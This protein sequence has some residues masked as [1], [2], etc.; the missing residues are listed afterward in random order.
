[1]GDID[2]LI[3]KEDLKRVHQVFNKEGYDLMARSLSH[4]VFTNKAGLM[5]EIHPGLNVVEEKTYTKLLNKAFDYVKLEEDYEYKFNT[6]Y[7]LTY[8]VYHLAKH[9]YSGGI[10]LRSV[11]DIGV[12]INSYQDDLDEDL[13]GELLKEN[14]LEV[15]FNYLIYINNYLF[16]YDFKFKSYN[17]YQFKEDTVNKLI[18]HITTSGIHGVGSKHNQFTSRIVSSNKK[19]SKF[20]FILKRTFPSYKEMKGFYPILNKLPFLL[21]V[22]YIVR[23]FKLVFIRGKTNI[24]KIKRISKSTEAKEME[25]LFKN[26]GL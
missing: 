2:I 15:F 11:L 12:F 26:V 8:L 17:K 7:E 25:D 14:D 3:K 21:P 6:T 18:K 23:L 20:K 16:K 1:M 5:V 10:G 13:L 19:Q 22:F 9:M 24:R 4:D